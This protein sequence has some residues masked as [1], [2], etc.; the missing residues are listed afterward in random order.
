[1]NTD[2]SYE[3]LKQD[4]ENHKAQSEK[5][6]EALQNTIA[7]LE[8]R[9]SALE[10]TKEKTDFQYEQ[11]M[12][13]LNKINDKTIPNLVS[14]LEELKNKPVKRYDQAITSV[15]GAI[16]GAIGGYLASLFLK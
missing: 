11:I 12:A 16:F 5:A 7:N 10:T 2:V 4:M 8:Q 3:L 9:M 14:Q 1:M 13:T 15:F 6:I